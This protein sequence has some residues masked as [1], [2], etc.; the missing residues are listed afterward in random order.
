MKMIF[1]KKRP[2]I[3][4]VDDFYT[5][6]NS[7]EQIARSLKF[8]TDERYYKG[9]RSQSM[10]F[11][12]VKEEF[13]RLL[14]AEI[15]DWTQ[16]PANGVFQITTG[17][18]PLVYHSDS[19]NYAAAVYLT[20]DAEDYGTS[21]WMHK[22]LKVRRPPSDPEIHA[23]VYNPFNILNP[24]NWHLVDKVGGVYNRLVIWDAK[25][26]H[27]A[28]MYGEKDRLVQLYFFNIKQ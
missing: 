2:S 21:F 6:P 26:I 8:H 28:S 14:G 27:S 23:Q 4:V 22:D 17:T 3:L 15:S 20:P 25:L 18:D 9:R 13:E 24:D 19:Q 5:D 10:L 12:F 7:V 16:Q 11:P 1:N